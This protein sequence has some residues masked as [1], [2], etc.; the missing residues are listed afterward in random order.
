MGVF[1]CFGMDS[2]PLQ[3][4][5]GRHCKDRSLPRQQ[6]GDVP[7]SAGAS[8]YPGHLG[9]WRALCCA[10]VQPG[11]KAQ[12]SAKEQPAKVVELRADTR[13][14][15]EAAPAADQATPAAPTR[16]ELL[17]ALRAKAAYDK[18]CKQRKSSELGAL[19][20]RRGEATVANVCIR[21][22]LREARADAREARKEAR[23]YETAFLQMEELVLKAADAA[24]VRDGKLAG[25]NEEGIPLGGLGMALWQIDI[26][27]LNTRQTVHTMWLDRRGPPPVDFEEV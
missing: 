7:K 16:Q 10:K 1:S 27:L 26:S 24:D 21:D 2:K 18:A 6:A 20:A 9:L 17:A 14:T 22:A 11:R 19:K 4:A 13:A 12:P 15:R 8:T 3:W 25:L 5:P 23:K